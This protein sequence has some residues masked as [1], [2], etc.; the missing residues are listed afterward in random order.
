MK[1]SMKL[2]EKCASWLKW[3]D[4]FCSSQRS[5]SCYDDLQ[6]TTMEVQSHLSTNG[7]EPIEGAP[8]GV[9]ILITN[10]EIVTCT[11]IDPKY[12]WFNGA[13]F[14]GYE[15]DYKFD[16]NEVTHWQPLP[17]PPS[18]QTHKGNENE[19]SEM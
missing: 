3:I 13:G 11:T 17:F 5:D 15:W 19:T 12:G 4:D 14:G 7:W 2:L 16:T 10:G 9:P 1:T 6:N 8:K 18:K